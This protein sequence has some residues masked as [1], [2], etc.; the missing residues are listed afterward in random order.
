M[1]GPLLYSLASFRDV[2]V[3][4]FRD[5]FRDGFLAAIRPWFTGPFHPFQTLSAYAHQDFVFQSTDVVLLSTAD[6]DI[7]SLLVRFD[8]AERYPHLRFMCV[9]HRIGRYSQ[10]NDIEDPILSRQARQLV[11]LLIEQGRLT[12]ITLSAHTQRA[13][14]QLFPKRQTDSN[15]TIPVEFFVPVSILQNMHNN[16]LRFW[17]IMPVDL[18]RPRHRPNHLGRVKTVVTQGKH[19]RRSCMQAVMI[20]AISGSLVPWAR[21]YETLFQDSL[22]AI[23]GEHRNDSLD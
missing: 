15:L 11:T 23:A 8:V 2:H 19:I 6:K 12:F 9:A 17:Q 5:T 18:G 20:K 7:E 13:L 4:C 1:L 16:L 3:T 14:T 22:K 10:N 21:T